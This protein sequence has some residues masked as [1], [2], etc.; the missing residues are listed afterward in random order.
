[1]P[2]LL[3]IPRVSGSRRL[4]DLSYLFDRK[5]F[6]IDVIYSA[7]VHKTAKKQTTYACLKSTACFLCTFLESCVGKSWCKQQYLFLSNSLEVVFVTDMSTSEGTKTFLGL[8]KK[9]FLTLISFWFPLLLFIPAMFR[10]AAYSAIYWQNYFICS[11]FDALNLH[12]FLFFGANF[13]K[14]GVPLRWKPA[15]VSLLNK[16]GSALVRSPPK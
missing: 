10:F 8:V 5:R 15:P 2:L 4:L 16:L 11:Q 13:R 6:V 7:G 9:I 1:M 14:I 3:Y 12:P